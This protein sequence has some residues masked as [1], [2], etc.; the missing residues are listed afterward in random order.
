MSDI[1]KELEGLPE[2]LLNELSISDADKVEFTI[3]QIID[4]NGGVISLDRLLVDMFKKT[5]KI[6]KRNA[7]TSKLYRMS[8][9]G[10]VFSVPNK[11]G[12]Y[13]TS[14]IEGEELNKENDFRAVLLS[15]GDK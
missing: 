10:M 6:Y 7:L 13:S 1:I 4:D 5:G 15:F 9:K 14:L 8:N 2:E 12:V 11:K 3:Q